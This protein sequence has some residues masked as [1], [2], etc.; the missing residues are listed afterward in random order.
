[1]QS[2]HPPT[3]TID[4]CD[5]PIKRRALCY[6]HYMKQ[7]RYG[8]AEHTPTRTRQDLTGQRFGNLVALR[9]E[10]NRWACA[11]DCGVE[12]HAR[13]GD[14]NRG[15]VTSCGGLTHRRMDV[16]GYTA[17]HDRLRTD[18]GPASTHTCTD[19]GAPADHWSYDHTDP[20]ERQAENI[21]GHPAYSLDPERYAPRCV[22][23]HKV[24]DLNVA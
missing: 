12:H 22:P 10:S 13:V 17:V 7:W 14:L 19:C 5:K 24:F 6:G 21:K 3:C 18:R 15:S 2:T 1:M 9:R 4:G 8:H 11:C 23:C 20:D 16:V